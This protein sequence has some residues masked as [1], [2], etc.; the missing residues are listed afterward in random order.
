VAGWFYY[1]LFNLGGI[2]LDFL[3][4]P[5]AVKF[6]HEAPYVF[7]VDVERRLALDVDLLATCLGEL[8]GLQDT[9]TPGLPYPVMGVHEEAKMSKHEVELERARLLEALRHRGMLERFLASA[10]SASFKEEEMW[11]GL[12]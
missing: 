11:G 5:L 3:G 6:S 10:R 4:E 12:L 8:A 2:G 7:R 1:P 9:A